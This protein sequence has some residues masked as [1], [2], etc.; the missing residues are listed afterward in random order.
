MLFAIVLLGLAAPAQAATQSAPRPVMPAMPAMPAMDHAA[1]PATPAPLPAE[2]AGWTRMTPIAAGIA[3]A[4]APSLSI[5]TGFHA[6]LGPGAA[7]GYVVAPTKPGEA[8]TSGGLFAV[9]VAA[10]GR[11]RVALGAGAWIDVLRDG[12]PIA[13]AAHDHGPA[14]SPVRKMVDFDLQPGRYV[15]QIVGS[16]AATLDLMIARLR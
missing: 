1:C 12:K 16:K 8:G 6:S 7:V 10:A 2:L 5:G 13:S 11:Y 9:T 15:L 3:P 4:A 14:C